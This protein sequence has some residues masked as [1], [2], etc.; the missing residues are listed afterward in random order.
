[1]SINFRGVQIFAVF[2]GYWQPTKINPF[3]VAHVSVY[4]CT[5]CCV[6]QK[7]K[8]ILKKGYGNVQVPSSVGGTAES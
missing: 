6:H 3:E 5:Y 4:M 7:C 2:V 8:K 1:M